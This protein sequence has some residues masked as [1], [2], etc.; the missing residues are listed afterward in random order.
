M[1]DTQMDDR[2][3]LKIIETAYTNE[4]S[5]RIYLH[6]LHRIQEI[7]GG[8]PL[9]QVVSNPDTFYPQLR[10]AFPNI[11]TRKNHLTVVLALFKHS[12]EL[13]TLAPPTARARWS[14]FHEDMDA[15]QR[16]RSKKNLPTASQLARYT[17]WEEIELKY[18]ELGGKRRVGQDP[19]ASMGASMEYLLISMLVHVP[20]K[21]CDYGH[22]RI[23]HGRDPH[24][25]DE[26]YV[27]LR[28]RV[29]AASKPNNSKNN[30]RP[31]ASYMV[32]TQY[33][34]AKFMGRIDEDLPLQAEADLLASLRRYPRDYLFVTRFNEPFQGPQAFSKFVIR[35]FRKL[36]GRDTGMT[37]LR[38]IYITEN[39]SWDRMT[40]EQLELVSKQ[41]M[42]SRALQRQY[43][44]NRS[45]IC[46]TL[47]KL[48]PECAGHK[49]VLPTRS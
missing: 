4:N 19:H 16:S 29:Q 9:F 21:R 6:R 26:N 1:K 46:D 17:P 42:H 20:P 5:A 7:S 49:K 39:L 13:S 18:K 2:E 14:K 33:K 11:A 15:F 44:W 3:I 45:A 8:Q 34:T 28:N 30:N 12:E 23:Y 10:A 38:H 24:K 37:M 48:C 31:S 25:N 32:F 40:D 22:M 41:M 27:V 43:H 35:V 36:F 47:R